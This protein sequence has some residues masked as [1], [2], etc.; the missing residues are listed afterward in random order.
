[1]P[2]QVG[3]IR[4][5]NEITVEQDEITDDIHVF[6]Q[7]CRLCT[8]WEALT[9]RL[10]FKRNRKEEVMVSHLNFVQNSH[11]APTSE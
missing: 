4:L 10:K 3:P 5:A 11:C 7:L 6:Y 8:T 1:M 2:H 9:Q